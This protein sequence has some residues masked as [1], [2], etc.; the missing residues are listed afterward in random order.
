MGTATREMER[1]PLLGPR[2][3]SVSPIDSVQIMERSWI[4]EFQKGVSGFARR[5]ARTRT[6][7]TYISLVLF[8]IKEKEREII[9]K[10]RCYRAHVLGARSSKG[11]G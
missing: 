10:Q 3:S 1:F 2:F 8:K 6:W 9:E 7:N 5:T 11:K 4:D